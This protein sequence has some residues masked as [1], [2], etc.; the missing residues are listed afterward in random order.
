MRPKMVQTP[1]GNANTPAYSKIFFIRILLC[2]EMELYWN[3]L[4][5][6]ETQRISDIYPQLGKVQRSQSQQ[7]LSGF[8]VKDIDVNKWTSF[9]FLK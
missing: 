8:F 3:R 1:R 7:T 9:I 6:T 2:W 4:P 5:P